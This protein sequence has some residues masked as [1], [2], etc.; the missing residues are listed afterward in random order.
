MVHA[1]VTTS[2]T[3]DPPTVQTSLVSDENVTA[4]PEEAVADVVIGDCKIVTFAGVPYVIVCAA[5][6]TVKLCWTGTAAVYVPFPAWSAWIVHVP[7]VTSVTA[8]P[9]TV[10][11]AVV[12]D[13]NETER[14]ELA[15][16]DVAIGDCTSVAFGSAANVI[17]CV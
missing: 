17:V 9:V 6:D 11:T 4:R 1:P 5:F 16:A 2:V 13:E 15:V 8:E 10:H 12:S 3:V 14:P 7:V